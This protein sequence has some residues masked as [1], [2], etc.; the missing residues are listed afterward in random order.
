MA[1]LKH[2]EMLAWKMSPASMYSRVFA[3]ACSIALACEAGTPP[4]DHR[5]PHGRGRLLQQLFQ[6]IGGARRACVHDPGAFLQ[7][8]KGDAGV[9]AMQH[10]LRPERRKLR[11]ARLWLQPPAKVVGDI[12]G[13]TALEWRQAGSHRPCI[14]AE[15][16]GQD[17]KRV[18]AGPFAINARFALHDRERRRRVAG[19]EGVAAKPLLTQR[20]FKQRQ[21]PFAFQPPCQL[22]GFT[23]DN[24]AHFD[25]VWL[26][27]GAVHGA[28]H[29]GL[30]ARI[31]QDYLFGKCLPIP[32][33][34]PMCCCR[35]P[36]RGPI[37]TRCRKAWQLSPAPMSACRSAPGR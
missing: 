3:T 9:E 29:I 18:F 26:W 8:V 35:S 21:M 7:M 11:N 37:P 12:A 17:G 24:L 5:A 10:Q 14:V 16:P 4:F 33:H 15:P 36:S 2:C 1:A 23:V 13:N 30:E 20:T 32:H 25:G 22:Q 34:L 19:E 6:L 31:V 27:H 28:H